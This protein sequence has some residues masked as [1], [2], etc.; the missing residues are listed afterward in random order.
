VD[1][2]GVWWWLVLW[3]GL[4]WVIAVEDRFGS[5]KMK[6]VWRGGGGKAAI[7]RWEA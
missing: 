2:V 4:R 3:W 6:C 5:E 7:E 1:V